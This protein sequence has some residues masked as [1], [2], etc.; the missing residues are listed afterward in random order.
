VRV[1]G[2]STGGAVGG[3]AGDPHRDQSCGGGVVVVVV[4]HLRIRP[5]RGQE[6]RRG[7][8]GAFGGPTAPPSLGT[9]VGA[10]RGGG[11]V[12]VGVPHPEDRL[13]VSR[14]VGGC[15][16]RGSPRR[17]SGGVVS[18]TTRVRGSSGLIKVENVH[19]TKTHGWA[20]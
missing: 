19:Q 9:L 13:G 2:A 4:A 11:V 12:V 10:S 16:D 5:D 20:L 3:A 14:G 15:V 8:A 1:A 7:G 18:V 17:A 6:S